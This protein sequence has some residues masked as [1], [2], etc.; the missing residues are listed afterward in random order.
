[1]FATVTEQGA[2]QGIHDD[3]VDA[4]PEQLI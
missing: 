3:D 4:D 1:M 2:D